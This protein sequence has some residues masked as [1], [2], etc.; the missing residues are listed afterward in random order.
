MVRSRHRIALILLLLGTAACAGAG[1]DRPASPIVAVDDL[2]DTV[3]LARPATRIASL[4]PATTELLFAVGLG[5]A[6]VGRT[7]WCDYPDSA[8]LVPSL[9][10]GL[11]PNLEAI[12]AARPDLVVLYNS[13]Q[14]LAAADRLRAQ[15]IAAV[16]L[17]TDRLDDVP[18]L[19]RLLARLGGRAEAGDSLADA[20][21]AALAAATRPAPPSPSRV[22]IV[23]WDQPPIVIGRGS[24]LSELVARAG[25]ENVFG[26]LAAASAPVSLEAIAGRSVDVALIFGDSAPDYAARPE[27]QAV[28]AVRARRFVY[29][30]A[31]LFS[32]PGPRSAEALLVLEAALDRGPP[33]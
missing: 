18:R 6:V 24:F 30:P 31:G 21:E 3:R 11:Q 2:G 28:P 4:I 10:D 1:R 12:V 15:G 32:R 16:V 22:L 14:N 19:A 29:L 7:T 26:D 20:F 33:S 13:T 8:R 5:P 25:A 23:A 17:S 9:G 27:W